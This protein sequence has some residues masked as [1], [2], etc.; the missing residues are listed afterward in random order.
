MK[1]FTVLIV[2][3]L[4]LE[5]LAVCDTCPVQPDHSKYVSISTPFKL[6]INHATDFV[7][8]GLSLEYQ[9]NSSIRYGIDLITSTSLSN[10]SETRPLQFA[11]SPTIGIVYKEWKKLTLYQKTAVGISTNNE[12]LYNSREQ[13]FDTK[14][15][16]RGIVSTEMILCY[17]LGRG[18][19]MRHPLVSY[20]IGF[21]SD[22]GA[23]PI[24]SNVP[25]WGYSNS[26]GKQ[27]SGFFTGLSI[28]LNLY[29]NKDV[30]YDF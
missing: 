12:R 19:K 16:S 3:M 25:Q 11:I 17:K 29:K 10:V 6:F 1:F 5:I 27:Y 28:G 9:T 23:I 15:V 21:A 14:R 4:N 13:S 2:T 30:E 26:G 20:N 7:T 22:L 24:L 8:G 18:N